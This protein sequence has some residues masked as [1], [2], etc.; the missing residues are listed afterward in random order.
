[1]T[2]KDRTY[3][4]NV[5]EER[6]GMNVEKTPRSDSSGGRVAPCF[7]RALAS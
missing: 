7:A 3:W 5:D 2:P 6:H 1:M 4:M